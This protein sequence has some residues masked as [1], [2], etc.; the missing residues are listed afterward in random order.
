MIR[1]TSAQDERIESP[2]KLNA[3]RVLVAL[4]V[5]SVLAIGVY[6]FP[7]YQRWASAEQTVSRDRLRLSTVTRGNLMRD[8]S[9]Q[10]KVT[11]AIKPTLFSPAGG[12]VTIMVQ[13]G[14]TVKKGELI[15][16]IESPEMLSLLQQETAALESARTS[17]KRQQIEARK[18][19]LA[20][21]QN[22]DLAE[23]QL[24][25]ARRELRRAEAAHAREA[26]SEFDY[27][28]AR[29]DVANAELRHVHAIEDA[30]LQLESLAFEL[31]TAELDIQRQQ[32]RVTELERQVAKLEIQSPVTG[33]VGNLLVEN[34]DAIA[35][36]Q[37]LLTVVDLTAFEVEIQV[38]DSY[39]SHLALGLDAEVSHEGNTYPAILVA[40]SPEVI[41]SQ[42]TAK[43][44]FS[45]QPPA[46]MKQNQRVTARVL[47][48][49]KADVL[50]VERGPFLESSGGRFTYVI[51]DGLA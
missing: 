15:A 51:K 26:I 31:Q 12:A 23:I 42:I 33:I 14:D 21:K 32:L 20:N 39:A 18:T 5:I 11:A 17:F 47:L 41:N 29:D 34:K 40:V 30:K 45:G 24:I 16:Q 35:A 27:D 44:R 7:S 36:N 43:V 37:P 6:A 13:A 9:A 8:I 4:V 48:E 10:G 50:L 19:G 1:D 3:T 49:S 28:K 46:N 38:P 25:A 2:R 22:V